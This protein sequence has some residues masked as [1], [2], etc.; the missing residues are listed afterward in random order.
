MIVEKQETGPMPVNTYI[1]KDEKSK[2]AI[3][4]D[5][6]GNFEQIKNQIELQGYKIKFVLNTHGHFDHVYG[7][8]YIQSNYPDIPIYIHKDDLGHVDKLKEEMNFFGFNNGNEKLILNKFIDENSILTIG[9]NKISIFHTP[10]HSKGSLSFHVDKKLF[11]GDALFYRSI[12]RTDFYDGDY[13]TLINS[14]KQK[15]FSLPDDT[16]VYPGHG[17]STTI[18]DEKL[19][20][21][22][23]K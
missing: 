4:I 16:V 8:P 9:D 15:L 7:E 12:G 21:E 13:N 3:L 20:N 6:G 5:V 22:Y 14:I 18:R 10:G 2:E 11:S 17:P 1:L 19:Y 23:L